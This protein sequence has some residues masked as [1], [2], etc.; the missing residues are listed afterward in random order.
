VSV[1]LGAPVAGPTPATAQPGHLGPHPEQASGRQQ[2]ALDLTIDSVDPQVVTVHGPDTLTVRGR[3]TN[4]GERRLTQLQARLQRGDSPKDTNALRNALRGTSE[5][6]RVLTDFQRI[7]TELEPGQTTSFELSVPLHDRRSLQINGPGVYPLLVNVNGRPDRGQVV[8]LAEQRLLLPVLGDPVPSSDR[9]MPLTLLWPVVDR[10]RVERVDSRGRLVLSGDELADSLGPGG[11]LHDLVQAVEQAAP[12]G[13]P[14]GNALCFVVDPDLLVTVDGMADGYLV[15]SGEGT[16]EGSG[17]DI[18]EVWLDQLRTAVR[19]RC[20]L[21]LP[22]ADPDLVALSRTGLTDL[23][24]TAFSQGAAVVQELLDVQ[25]I[26]NTAWPAGGLVDERSLSELVGLGM[27][28]VLLRPEGMQNEPTAGPVGLSLGE[29]GSQLGP[30]ALPVDPLVADALARTAPNPEEQR[31]ETTRR[32]G[33]SPAVQDALGAMAHRASTS[34]ESPLLVAPP[35]RWDL[36]RADLEALLRGITVLGN[37]GLVRPTGLAQLATMP[38]VSDSTV[39]Y[40]VEN[41]ELSSRIVTQIATAWRTQRDLYDSMGRDD[42]LDVTPDDLLAPV[43][44][45]LL[46][47]GSTAWRSDEPQAQH[48]VWLANDVLGELRSRVTVVPASTEYTLAS[49]DSPLPLTI[50]N[51]LPVSI[52]VKVTVLDPPGVR[53]QRIEVQRLP[54]RGSRPLLVSAEVSRSGRFSIDVSLTTPGGTALGQPVRLRMVS[55]A[56]GTVTTAITAAAAVALVVLSARRVLRRI[57]DR[58]GRRSA[59]TASTGAPPQDGGGHE[60]GSST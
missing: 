34:P 26:P 18:A 20:V 30:V 25:P 12:P 43:R 46:R 36:S 60:E 57:R 23:T 1:L 11:R 22:F 13:S 51:E 6:S 4:R 10:P 41:R 19:G 2:V 54:A 59:T 35:R 55:S 52:D 33:T 32:T 53:T 8:R 39:T 40:P 38:V 17:S 24:E 47:G 14:L 28:T 5:P 31:D 16:V 15:R 44:Q 21:A 49:S 45:G 7:A 27:R 58:A 48:W 56:Y 3:I 29:R 50:S 37:H 9:S 42:A